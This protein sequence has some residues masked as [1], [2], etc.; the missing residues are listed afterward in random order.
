MMRIK[1]FFVKKKNEQKSKKK[2]K[3][4]QA[5]GRVDERA[6]ANRVRQTGQAKSSEEEKKSR[7]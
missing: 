2:F 3:S 5:D 6:Q 7:T 4:K 1:I